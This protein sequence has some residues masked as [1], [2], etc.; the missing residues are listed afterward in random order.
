M[1]HLYMLCLCDPR[2]DNFQ[3]LPL[4]QEQK[5]PHRDCSVWPFATKPKALSLIVLLFRCEESGCV[6]AG[7][8]LKGDD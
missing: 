3:S 8:C 1:A 7:I 6:T 5:T 2:R 4:P